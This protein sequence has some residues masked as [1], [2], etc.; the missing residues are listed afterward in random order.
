MPSFAFHATLGPN[1]AT[2]LVAGQ[3]AELF[4]ASRFAQPATNAAVPDGL[5]ADYGSLTTDTVVDFYLGGVEVTTTHLRDVLCP[6]LGSGRHHQQRGSQLDV[7]GDLGAE[8]DERP[9]QD[10]EKR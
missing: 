8:K 5:A 10:R 3:S 4:R 2:E 1:P 6:V 9:E 7:D